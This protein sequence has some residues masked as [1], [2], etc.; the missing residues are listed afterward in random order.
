MKQTRNSAV[1]VFEKRVHSPHM[2]DDLTIIIPTIGR[3]ILQKCL[4]A[5]AQG[6]ALPASVIVID[7]GRNL[8]I[9]DWLSSLKA[10]GTE[11]IYLSS[12]EKGP[13][14]ARNSGIAMVQTPFWAAI[15]D[16]C[17]AETD[18][19]EKM[20]L[21]L[22]QNPDA[23]ITGRVEPAG[24]GI[25][26]TIVVSQFPRMY[27]HPSFRVP[28]PLTSGNMGV[29]QELV[30]QIGLFDIRLQ[31]AEDNDWA[32][33]ALRADIPIFYAPDVIVHHFHWRNKL[34]VAS[35][36]RSYALGQGAFYGKHLRHGDLSMV[37]GVLLSLVRGSRD[38]LYGITRNDYAQRLN[39][40]S[41]ILWL[42][43][44]VVSGMIR[45]GRV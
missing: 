3:P 35:T 39:G 31:T 28:S 27:R 4:Q 25:A 17:I 13:A 16:D 43:P 14:S 6:S 37:A 24:D 5:I 40:I 26:P 44:G 29:R 8:Q 15:D 22:S 9:I 20:R 32:Y 36:Y 10:L 11:T 7:Q 34:E 18:W 12:S 23:V 30:R 42:L 38:L 19:L 21:R 45:F 1:G 2:L 33:R 41:R